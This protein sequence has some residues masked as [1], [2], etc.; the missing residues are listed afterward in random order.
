MNGSQSD[1]CLLKR[2]LPFKGEELKWFS[3][4]TGDELKAAARPTLRQV[5]TLKCEP[6]KSILAELKKEYEGK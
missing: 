3:S 2:T 4:E 5:R 6:C 1:E